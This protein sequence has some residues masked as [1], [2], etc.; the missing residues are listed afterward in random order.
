MKKYINYCFRHVCLH[1]SFCIDF[2]FEI[3]TIVQRESP[4]FFLFVSDMLSKYEQMSIN[5]F[6]FVYIYI[7]GSI[8]LSHINRPLLRKKIKGTKWKTFFQAWHHRSI[9][10]FIHINRR[11]CICVHREKDN[12]IIWWTIF[13]S[14]SLILSH[15]NQMYKRIVF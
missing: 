6:F 2:S 12:R 15:L 3:K 9:N 1:I 8:Y 4:F 13:F 10:T 11:A 5:P 7:Q 14:L